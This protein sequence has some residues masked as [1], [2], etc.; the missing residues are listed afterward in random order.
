MT[1]PIVVSKRNYQTH[2]NVFSLPDDYSLR[3]HRSRSSTGLRKNEEVT[4]LIK[5]IDDNIV[6]KNSTFQGPFGRRKG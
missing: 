3:T 5:Y 2:R 6:G 4:K 1:S